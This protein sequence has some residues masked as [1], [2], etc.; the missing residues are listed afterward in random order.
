MKKLR[1]VIDSLRS[2]KEKDRVVKKEGEDY[3]KVHLMTSAVAFV[4]EKLRTFVDYKEEHLLR[5]NAIYRI[6]KRR[7]I[8]GEN[9]T[10]TSA[11]LIK[12]LISAKYLENGKVPEFQIKEVAT[13]IEKYNQLF[14]EVKNQHGIKDSLKVYNWIVG[15]AACEIEGQLVPANGEKALVRFLYNEL[16]QRIDIVDDRIDEEEKG[17]QLYLAANRSL[18]KSDRQMLDYLILNLF[19]PEWK[20]DPDKLT[21]K[22]AEDIFEIRKEFDRPIK[23]RLANKLLKIS[24]PYATKVMILREVI[25]NNFK[26][27]DLLV[28]DPDFWQEKIKEVCGKK[29]KETRARLKRS[30]LRSI[31]YVFIT[32]MSLAL[33]LEIPVDYWLLGELNYLALAINV[34]VPPLLMFIIAISIKSPS[35]K[36]TEAMIS[37]I[38]ELLSGKIKE[39]KYV[40]PPKTRSWLTRVVFNL[41]YLISFLL[42]IVFIIWILIMLKFTILSIFLFL[43]FLSI[44]SFFG[45]RIRHSARELVVLK[46]KENLVTEIFDFLTLPLIRLGRWLSLNFSKV[47]IFVFV[48][49]FI[50]E[51]PLKLI[52][53]V[54]EEWMGFM[55]EKKEELE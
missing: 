39:V 44:V 16:R 34:T 38:E 50:I 30:I 45:V 47:N 21:V 33:I 55:R 15:L 49:D 19:Y 12:E 5:K 41:I 27:A 10:K 28:N 8:E 29:Y 52:L 23:H 24:Q 9:Y 46:P 13:I 6:L 26:Q 37:G 42:P 51:A 3:I 4:Y 1:K 32:K 22:M 14:T 25:Y 17:L 54:F 7:F 35:K 2:A 40:K 43:V 36:N 18:I 53:E 11:N 20:T 31:V 48:L